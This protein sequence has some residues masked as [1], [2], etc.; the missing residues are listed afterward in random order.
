MGTLRVEP[1]EKSFLSDDEYRNYAHVLREAQKAASG[2]NVYFD[3]DDSESPNKVRKAL[4]H[5]AEKEGIPVAIR[6]ERGTKSLALSFKESG[7]GTNSR[8]SAGECR[9]RIIN[10]LASSRKALQK[11]EIIGITGISPSTWNIR[12]KELMDDG[13][14]KRHGDRR[15]TKYSLSA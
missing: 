15:D 1:R 12:I 9:K 14:V 8:M 7:R 6:R 3:M 13:R 4:L 5:I 2:N 11:S 10:A